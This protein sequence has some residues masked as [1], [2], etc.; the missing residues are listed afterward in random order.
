[1]GNE[2]EWVTISSIQIYFLSMG[3]GV[4]C[5]DG[6]DG[7]DGKETAKSRSREKSRDRERDRKDRDRR[8]VFSSEIF[9]LGR[10]RG[11]MLCGMGW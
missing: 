6:K 4:Y 7:K 2:R 1:M 3:L 8:V 9:I 5:E 10:M 11:L